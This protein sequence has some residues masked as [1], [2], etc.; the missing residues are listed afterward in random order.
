VF[1]GSWALVEA[2]GSRTLGGVAL[3]AGALALGLLWR[4]RNGTRVAMRLLGTGVAAFVASHVLALALGA[5]ASVLIVAATM[6]W[7]TWR[8]SDAR[9][10]VARAQAP[11]PGAARPAAPAAGAATPPPRAIRRAAR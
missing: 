5:W 8:L 4:R 2:S 9:P 6:A 3:L 11:T 1:V 7:L 10:A